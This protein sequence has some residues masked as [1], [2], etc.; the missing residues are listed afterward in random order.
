M[1]F[2]DL[3][4][5]LFLDLVLLPLSQCPEILLTILYFIGELITI[6]DRLLQRTLLVSVLTLGSRF[7]Q[8]Q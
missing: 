3:L 2:F 5:F 8:F 4:S 1:S 7:S 6:P